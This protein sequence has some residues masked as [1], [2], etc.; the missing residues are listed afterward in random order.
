MPNPIPKTIVSI[1]EKLCRKYNH[2]RVM[3]KTVR[4]ERKKGYLESSRVVGDE[5][6]HQPC[7]SQELGRLLA[8]VCPW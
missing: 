5:D 4:R 8:I 7:L 3:E 1:M 2:F 6:R